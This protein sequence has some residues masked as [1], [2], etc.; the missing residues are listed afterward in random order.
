M[1]PLQ[2]DDKPPFHSLPTPLWAFDVEDRLDASPD[3]AEDWRIAVY[4]FIVSHPYITP[5]VWF[6]LSAAPATVCNDVLK[7]HQAAARQCNQDKQTAAAFLSVM[8][9]LLVMVGIVRDNPEI[10]HPFPDDLLISP[11]NMTMC[12]MLLILQALTMLEYTDDTLPARSNMNKVLS[13]VQD[14][15]PDET[16][17][18]A[19][20]AAQ[21]PGIHPSL[22]VKVIQQVLVALRQSLKPMPDAAS[23]YLDVLAQMRSLA[24]E[25]LVADELVEQGRLLN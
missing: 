20:L 10:G 22:V 14:D 9:L 24:P 4:S 16:A 17:A 7:F 5:S 12:S 21:P 6:S 19:L 3:T 1:L 13:L 15:L 18:Q 8:D 23:L 25:A 2:T 11:P